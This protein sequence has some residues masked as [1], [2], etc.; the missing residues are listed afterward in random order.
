MEAADA[1]DVAATF[2]LGSVIEPPELAARGANGFIWKVTTDRGAFAV[3]RLRPWIESEPVPFDVHVQHA[4]AAAGI[5]L[6]RPVLTPTGDAMVE[7]TRVYEWVELA[8][9]HVAPVAPAVSREVGDLL[10][11]L[12]RLAL[13]TRE[14]ANRWYVQ[15]PSLDE[16]RDV[17]RRGADAEAPWMSWL[18]GEVD[19]LDELSRRVAVRHPG[20]M[21]TCHLDF[22]PSNVL[23]SAH[24]G[25]LVVLDWENTGAL[26]AG[27]ELAE[28]LLTWATAGDR[29]DAVAIA[30]LLDGY[31]TAPK[32][33]ASSFHMAVVTHL[34]YLKVNLDHSLQEGL[35]GE[36]VDRWIDDLQPVNLRERLVGIDRLAA[37]LDT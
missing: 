21:I 20:P 11:R 29:A 5:P 15:P 4:A 2:V 33:T 23:P 16:W 24:D 19:F 17:E 12:H 7:H 37:L 32:L 9:A 10:G 14:D 18:P 8:D 6:P 30:A 34:N 28:V 35:R 31:G 22:G 25:S 1:N 27:A 3:K 26:P 36:F 13:P